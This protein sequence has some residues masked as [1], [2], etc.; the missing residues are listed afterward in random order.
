[1]RRDFE[2]NAVATCPQAVVRGPP[3]PCEGCCLLAEAD[4]RIA[5]HLQMLNAN[6]RLKASDLARQPA[7]PSQAAV[8]LLLVGFAAQLEAVAGLHRALSAR[9]PATS[10]DLGGH[11][12]EICAPFA[13]GLFGEVAIA[14]DF[15]AGCAVRPDQ[16]LPLTQVFSEVLT[17][18]IKHGRDTEAPVVISARCGWNSVGDVTVE[19]ADQGPGLPE[20]FDPMADGGLGFRLIRALV[21]QLGARMQFKS[22][23]RGARFRLTLPLAC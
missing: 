2:P 22:S 7:A 15:P 23:H 12:R 21:A 17:N 14:Q 4:H 19:I 10:V 13:S 1:M 3:S 20:G 18:A 5:N 9:T 6:M 16:L 11:L 8:G